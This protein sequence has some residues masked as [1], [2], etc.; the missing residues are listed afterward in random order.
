M[1][2]LE[3]KQKSV[4]YVVNKLDGIEKHVD[5]FEFY[6]LGLEEALLPVSAAHNR[7]VYE[8]VEKIDDKLNSLGY[9]QDKASNPDSA[10]KVALIGRPNAGKSSV[11]NRITGSE[12]RLSVSFQGLPAI[13]SIHSTNTMVMISC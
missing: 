2:Y 6:S 8:V 4:V 7:G 12:R 13:V 1:K 9:R 3:F 11:L 5:M 10:T